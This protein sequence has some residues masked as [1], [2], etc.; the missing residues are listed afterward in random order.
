MNM[1]RRRRS[2]L[3]APVAWLLLAH[4]AALYLFTTGFFLTRFEVPDVSDC[5][6]HPA[7]TSPTNL[8]Q[9]LHHQSLRRDVDV[10]SAAT[11][12]CWMPAR[13]RRVVFV[14]VDALRFDFVRS[15]DAASASTTASS[16]YYLD[17]LPV[18]NETLA[19]RPSQSLL[20]KFVADPPTMTMQRLKGLT[21]GSL[22]TFLDIKDNMAS[23]SA[24]AEDNLLRQMRAQGRG[25][26]FMG[27]DTWDALYG[28]A[29]FTRKYA[30]DSFN[31]KDLDTVDRGVQRHLFPE[32]QRGDW[33]LLIAHFL[34]V[35]HVGHTHGPSSV[36]MTQKLDE[37]NR[38]LGQLLDALPDDDT[39]LAV[40]GDH[41]MSADGN[42]GGATDEETGA[43]L[44]LYSK[45]PIVADELRSYADRWGSEIPQVDLVPTL[46]L[47]SG[48]PIPFGNLGSV[49]PSLFFSPQPGEE[50]SAPAGGATEGKAGLEQRLAA[51]F[52]SLAVALQLN[53]EQVRRYLWT[54]SS[55]SKLPAQAY[56]ALERMLLEI[57]GVKD[58]LAFLDTDALASPSALTRK[59][60]LLEDLVSRQQ[61]YLREALALGRSI[62]TQFD[63]CS[64]AWG[65]L[66]FTWSLLLLVID[67]LNPSASVI[68]DQRAL[69]VASV[70]KAAV[71][72]MVAGSV[73]AV[74]A[75]F[76]P[77]SHPLTRWLP[78]SPLSRA[79]V[80]VASL[81]LMS[82]SVRAWRLR[83][84][85][86]SAVVFV[87]STD[88]VRVVAFV[89]VLLH[90][91]ALLSNSYIVAEDKVMTF[92]SETIGFFLLFHAQR[93]GS[94]IGLRRSRTFASAVFIA[95]SRL[96]SA[97]EPPNIIQSTPSLL[98]TYIPLVVLVA[99]AS[100]FAAFFKRS[101]C[102]GASL[103]GRFPSLTIGVA[104]NCVA[105][106]VYW[107]AAPSPWAMLRLW[108]PRA[109]YLSFL[110]PLGVFWWRNTRGEGT[111]G[112][113]LM[114][115]WQFV[116]CYMLV[117]GPSSPVSVLSASLQLLSLAFV[118]RTAPSS[119]GAKPTAAS[120]ARPAW[121]LLFA[122]ATSHA[123]FF[124]GH[125]NTFTSLQN[126]A[127]FVGLDA[128]QFHASGA[129][130]GLNTF[131]NYALGL[132]ALP[133]VLAGQEPSRPPAAWRSALLAFLASLALAAGV[134]TA[135]VALQRRHLM[136][137]A[138]FAPK[139]LFDGVVLLVADAL[140]LL[141]LAPLAMAEV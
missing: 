103:D 63:L 55:A 43:A 69:T 51:S 99:L 60:E 86:T 84:E 90:S 129:L 108:L 42:H 57:D 110:A 96:A 17:R 117:L 35:D 39:L 81:A 126:A 134:S 16:F 22:P 92:L 125:Q 21:T 59:I 19:A 93:P 4:A 124:T 37:M 12:E 95:S 61:R 36:F 74:S 20:F 48:L 114:L 136:V 50:G 7:A 24:I 127:G 30:F 135:F 13:F 33:D 6:V 130:L 75:I 85:M 54:Y 5:R 9:N 100:A 123:F 140:A 116:P 11:D 52:E 15:G 115:F 71:V 122:S 14:V 111:T 70:A 120:A 133:W 113:M 105:C 107:A 121:M 101:G 88:S 2:L 106:A 77:S 97:L 82:T 49:I 44:F 27:D 3:L 128:F 34:G 73:S 132:L 94:A 64:M 65:F 76:M 141:L 80:V 62:W 10:D 58:E 67:C 112:L 40:L 56:D 102:G 72:V 38:V 138:I 47:L 29:F 119:T 41:G 79:L 68:C 118:A 104:V 89:V 53:V 139:F 109:V 25:I 131:G 32:L 83:R 87:G 46:A 28:D 137:W 8:R 26:V 78:A 31:V 45:R 91:L 23:S 98:R 18:L 66:L 1:R